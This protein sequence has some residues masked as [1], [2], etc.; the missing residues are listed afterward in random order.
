MR[1]IILIIFITLI[2]L[3][4]LFAF[5]YKAIYTNKIN[6]NIDNKKILKL[7]TPFSST[8]I[9]STIIFI[10]FLGSVFIVS[11][12]KMFNNPVENKT[13]IYGVDEYVLSEI[14]KN[15]IYAIYAP[16]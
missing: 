4:V 1:K 14:G 9:F 6:K 3:I 7:L 11:D 10:L 5:F 12:S 15:S 8:L 16:I 13:P 2:I